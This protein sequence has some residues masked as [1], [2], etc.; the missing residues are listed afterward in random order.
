MSPSLQ[1]SGASTGLSQPFGLALDGQGR[2]VVTNVAGNSIAIY[3]AGANGN[4]APIRTIAGAATG[5]NVPSGVCLDASGT[6]YV[7]NA[8][9][10]ANGNSITEYAAGVAGNVAP[11]R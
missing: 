11:A 4:V 2:L 10:N 1:V 7:T 3:A 6:I 8:N 5:L 9:A